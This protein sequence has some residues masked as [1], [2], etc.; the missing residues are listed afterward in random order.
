MSY[1][2]LQGKK[3][4]IF[5]ALNEKSIAWKIAVRAHEEG[6]VFTLTNLPVSIRFGTIK[7]L[8]DQCNAELIPADATKTEDLENLLNRS[9]EIL[10]GKLDFILHSIGMSPNVRKDRDYDDLDYNYFFDTINIS[11][12]SFHKLLQQAKKMDAINEW[13]SVVALSY[14]AAQRT[15][16]GSVK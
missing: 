10:G 12:L 16:H 8:C 6:A 13:G 5:G 9:M 2:L 1:N 11:A 4:I 14:I 7:Q 3:G 15:L